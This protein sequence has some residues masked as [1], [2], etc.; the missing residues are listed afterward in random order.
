[1]PSTSFPS[2]PSDPAGAFVLG[3]ARALAARGYAIEVIAPEPDRAPAWDAPAPGVRV[4]WVPYLRPR[5]LQRT[6]HRAG[7]PENFARDPLAWLGAAPAMAAL[8]HAIAENAPRWDAIVSHWGVPCGALASRIADGRPHLAFF[9]GSDVHA[10][11]R[12]RAV[13][14]R[15]ARGIARGASTLA[16]PSDDLRDR[17]L[18][19]APELANRCAVLPMGVDPAP[20]IDRDA[21][22][23]ALGLVRPTLLAM[24]RLVPIKG[25]DRAIDA[26]A[27]RADVELV[28][29]GEGPERRALEE[30]AR[31]RR[32]RVRFVGVIRGD[33]KARW[34][35]AADALI[36]PS[37]VLPS[38]RAD[39]APVAAREALAAGLPVIASALPGLREIVGEAG[40]LCADQNALNAAID[41]LATLR[42]ALGPH[43]RARGARWV[44]TSI[45]TEIEAYLVAS[46]HRAVASSPA[47]RARRAPAR[48]ITAGPAAPPRAE[49]TR[50]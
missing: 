35:V 25:I 24:G 4:R 39:A 27:G 17:F 9:H 49:R 12:L 21:A 1:M 2:C 13:G 6:F 23:R 46:A 31:A 7:A 48:A 11:A 28:I 37:R 15:L 20:T 26:V 5:A 29:A 41:R 45:A 22:R 14:A 3:A 47:V 30:R 34:L 40:I 38:G 10:L 18:A 8:A 32:A 50:T 43:A 16:F 42:E 33:E 44:W 19:L 36:V